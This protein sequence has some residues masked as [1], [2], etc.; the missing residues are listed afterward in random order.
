MP[1]QKVQVLD[2]LLVSADYTRGEMSESSG[3][4]RLVLLEIS[5]VL[6]MVEYG[7]VRDSV[8][9]SLYHMNHMSPEINSGIIV[10][11]IL[12]YCP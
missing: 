9:V 3:Y 2:L 4:C 10:N 1:R 11:C 12:F 8:A 6:T 7:E 5:V